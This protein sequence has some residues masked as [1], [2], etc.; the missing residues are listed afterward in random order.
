MTTAV[1][2][3]ASEQIAD[4]SARAA[5]ALEYAEEAQAAD[6]IERMN[7]A[8][9]RYFWRVAQLTF[10]QQRDPDATCPECEQGEA[11]QVEPDF[12]QEGGVM[13]CL[14]HADEWVRAEQATQ[15]A[16]WRGAA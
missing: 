16:I 3:P 4:L 13:L 7:K 6:D 8:V 10:L 2:V 5:R 9:M 15:Y 14:D 1:A 11:W 12:W